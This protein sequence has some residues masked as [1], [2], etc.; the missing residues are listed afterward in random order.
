MMDN[1]YDFTIKHNN[2]EVYIRL[3]DKDS[4]DFALKCLQYANNLAK[5][6]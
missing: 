2:F 4:M 5:M 3:R 6:K 1:E